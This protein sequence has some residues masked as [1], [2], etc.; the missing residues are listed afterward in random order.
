MAKLSPVQLEILERF[1]DEWSRPI[2]H[3]YRGNP[4][5]LHP[6]RYYLALYQSLYGPLSLNQIA[7]KAAVGVSYGLLKMLR[8]QDEFKAA[9]VG[10]ARA[11]ANYLAG[12]ILEAMPG[13]FVRR[14]VLTQIIVAL[15]GFDPGDNLLLAALADALAQCEADPGQVANFKKLYDLLI[16]VR[17]SIRLAHDATPVI[18]RQALEDRVH[19]AVTPLLARVDVAIKAGREA[20]A[21][22]EQL[23]HVIDGMAMSIQFLASYSKIVV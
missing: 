8:L 17:D 12:K 20:G 14:L 10:N 13:D 16:C 9:M 2:M 11:F 23:A 7:E 22:D 4:G 3:E 21:I 19:G 6:G 15:P 5:T 1:F 18:Q